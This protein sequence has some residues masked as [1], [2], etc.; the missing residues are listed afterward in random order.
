MKKI[1][2][3][4]M[5]ALLAGKGS[6]AADEAGLSES[7]LF[8]LL[9]EQRDYKNKSGHFPTKIGDIYGHFGR[10]EK[11]VV[12]ILDSGEFP[13]MV[14]LPL[15]AFIPHSAS[16][17]S[18]VPAIIH[19]HGGPELK[20]DENT[21]HAEIAYF[22]SHGI[23]VFCPN[24]RGSARVSSGLGDD[25][26]DTY[27]EPLELQREMA[28][29][30]PKRLGAEDILATIAF[31]RSQAFVK[32]D[33]LI[34][35]G[36]SYG[37]F[38]NSQFLAKKGRE[39]RF[40]ATGV[41][42]VHFSGGLDYPS[43]AQAFPP[44]VAI[45]LSHGEQ[46]DITPAMGAWRLW[47][48]LSGL[49]RKN[50]FAFF[51][52][53]GAHHLIDPNFD[54]L[55]RKAPQSLELAKYVHTLSSFVL[56]LAHGRALS[57]DRPLPRKS[58]DM[59]KKE[60]RG[61]HRQLIK[62]IA[63]AELVE[64][65]RSTLI[66][67]P[68]MGPTLTHMR[69]ALGE[70]FTGNLLKDLKSFFGS[71]YKPIDWSQ[72]PSL[73]FLENGNRLIAAPQTLA[74]LVSMVEKEREYLTANP[75][76]LVFYHA[77]GNASLQLYTLY[78][79]W[80]SL[81]TG[82]EASSLNRLRGTDLHCR[83][84]VD[85]DQFLEIMRV[86]AEREKQLI[87]NNCSGYSKRAIS[88]TTMLTSRANTAS[89]SWYW[90]AADQESTGSDDRVPQGA[91]ESFLKLAGIYTPEKL[92]EYSQL[93][94]MYRGPRDKSQRLMQQIF[95]PASIADTSTTLCEMWGRPFADGAPVEMCRPSVLL[96]LNLGDGEAVEHT[97]D[98]DFFT[99][100]DLEIFTEISDRERAKVFAGFAPFGLDGVQ[101]RIHLR[102]GQALTYSYVRDP[103]RFELFKSDLAV[104]LARDFL[105]RSESPIVPSTDVVAGSPDGLAVFQVSAAQ[106][107]D[108]KT[109]ISVAMAFGID[110][111]QL[112]TEASAA[113]E[114]SFYLR[115]LDFALGHVSD[116]D[117]EEYV[118][119]NDAMSR[120]AKERVHD[121]ILAL[122]FPSR[123]DT[124]FAFSYY[125]K[126]VTYFDLIMSGVKRVFP[127]RESAALIMEH[128][129]TAATPY[130]AQKRPALGSGS[131]A[132]LREAFIRVKDAV[133][134][135]EERFGSPM[136]IEGLNLITTE[137][138]EFFERTLGDGMRLA[139]YSYQ[140]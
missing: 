63:K 76:W 71:C 129:K 90:Y 59:Q 23:A 41:R 104:L 127:T 36:G 120:A 47:D 114:E 115:Q 45:L 102:P 140:E 49:P 110:S 67:G 135:D 88:A 97:L 20:I 117:F 35:R 116:F 15:V 56:D 126:G 60:A 31:V 13:L 119:L 54:Y 77:A 40:A 133:H 30:D 79:L 55:N 89:S 32:K 85:V 137:A 84:T 34:L 109:E 66:G 50:V 106:K 26:W 87:P 7:Q 39:K 27:V 112:E 74:Q 83:H 57:L 130:L 91:L 99:R 111:P 136:N 52:K 101:A 29:N 81:V 11:T 38:L 48:K 134:Y 2:I 70:T 80:N 10:V 98:K 132:T 17:E 51:A 121:R 96:P 24:Y 46:D 105:A 103:E 3:Y 33:N 58:I 93:F 139:L 53:Y 78:T 82:Q 124:V 37:S 131:Y 22:L 16:A 100:P 86:T 62:E 5:F 113:D 107:Q 18:P 25:P 108:S 19:I 8:D 21:R 64:K 44:E 68:I 14:E 95:M 28:K 73:K 94:Q 4:L 1:A 6:F 128:L 118:R 92:R 138:E 9:V 69:M 61:V 123:E 43:D 65:N 122:G 72:Q 42:G 12:P 125:F 75:D